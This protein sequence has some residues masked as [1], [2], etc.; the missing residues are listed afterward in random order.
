MSRARDLMEDLGWFP[1]E[2]IRQAWSEEKAGKLGSYSPRT[3]AATPDDVRSAV[4]A[5]GFKNNPFGYGYPF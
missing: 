5:K 1:G 4:Q 3:R 2:A